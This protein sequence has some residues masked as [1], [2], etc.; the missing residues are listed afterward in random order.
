MRCGLCAPGPSPTPPHLAALPPSH[1]LLRGHP[2]PQQLRG[3]CAF[4]PCSLRL[5]GCLATGAIRELDAARR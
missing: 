5:I 2:H 4:S 3:L 1:D